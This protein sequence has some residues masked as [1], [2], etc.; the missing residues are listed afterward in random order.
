[1]SGNIFTDY[2]KGELL[3]EAKSRY[4]VTHSTGSYTLFEMLLINKKKTNVGGLSFNYTS[5]PDSFKGNESRLTEMIIGK[6]SSSI[7]SVYV[8]NLEKN[9]V[10]YGDVKNNM[11]AMIIFFDEERKAIEIFIARGLK[12][13]KRQLYSDVCE[14]YYVEEL[15]Q[16]RQRAKNVFKGELPNQ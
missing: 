2:Y 13:D 1:M 14:G 9:Y 12:H 6:G 4:D 11:D 16:L 10:G 8:P 15:E 3:T 5:R 7:S